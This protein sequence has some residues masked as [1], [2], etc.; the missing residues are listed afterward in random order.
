MAGQDQRD[1]GLG[2]APA[3]EEGLSWRIYD[4]DFAVHK[5]RRYHE[6]LCAF[7]SVWRDCVKIVTV[8]AGSGAAFLLFADAKPAAEAFAS[9]VALW[10][11]LDYMVAPDKKAEKHSELRD[12]FIELAIK[13]RKMPLT[14]D[15]YNKLAGERLQI[16]KDEPPCKRLVDLQ[17]RNE[18]CRARNFPAEDLVPLSK[19]QRLLG[20]FVT[21]GME[22][23]ENWQAERQRQVSASQ[24]R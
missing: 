1:N 7:Y 23:L 2:S 16:E 4:L 5:C 21:F 15:A 19:S 12:R 6:K 3:T 22:R 24:A 11:A 17:A 18:E 8:A 9:F 13:V 10:A 20:Y 14:E